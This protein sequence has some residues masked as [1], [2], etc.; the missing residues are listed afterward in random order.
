[1]GLRMG[2]KARVR[3]FETR[4]TVFMVCIAWQVRVRECFRVRV[5]VRVRV[6]VRVKAW[7][8]SVGSSIVVIRPWPVSSCVLTL[9]KAEEAKSA[10][11]HRDLCRDME[12]AAAFQ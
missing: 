12:G 3:S 1:M 6:S 8:E 2:T 5:R 4:H 11:P 9:R 7:E 10:H